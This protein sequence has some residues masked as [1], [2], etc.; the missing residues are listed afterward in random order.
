[1]NAATQAEVDEP[2]EAARKQLIRFGEAHKAWDRDTK[3]STEAAMLRAALPVLRGIEAGLAHHDTAE[4]RTSAKA[5][6]TVLDAVEDGLDGHGWP[7]LTIG[8]AGQGFN[9]AQRRALAFGFAYIAAAR[10]GKVR[11][12]DPV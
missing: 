9:L 8:K 6:R 5:L 3:P 1:M 7:S 4:V 2:D 11:D 12:P 10:A